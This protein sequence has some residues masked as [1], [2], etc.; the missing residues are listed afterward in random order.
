MVLWNMSSKNAPPSVPLDS[1]VQRVV[2]HLKVPTGVTTVRPF[3]V[4]NRH[5]GG[6]AGGFDEIRVANIIAL[7]L[8]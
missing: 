5:A 2:L 1:G 7:R 4:F 8:A 3:V 6:V